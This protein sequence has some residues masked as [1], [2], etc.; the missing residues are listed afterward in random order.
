MDPRNSLI[1]LFVWEVMVWLRSTCSST[2]SWWL[3]PDGG[4]GMATGLLS[5]LWEQLDGECG[6]WHGVIALERL[7]LVW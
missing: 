3:R 2:C 6:S 7:G 5:V 1:D 4:I